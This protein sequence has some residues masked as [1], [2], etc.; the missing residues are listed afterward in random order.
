MPRSLDRAVPAVIILTAA[1]LAS[2][3]AEGPQPSEPAATEETA[4]EPVTSSAPPASASDSRYPDPGERQAM[5]DDQYIE[6]LN[7]TVPWTTGSTPENLIWAGLENCVVHVE[8]GSYVQALE[9]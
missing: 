9:D 3:C 5:S 4:T 1:L 6:A 7:A 8:N 2:G